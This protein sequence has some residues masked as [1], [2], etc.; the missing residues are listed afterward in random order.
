V[1]AVT[2][3]PILVTQVTDHS[4]EKRNT[5]RAIFGSGGDMKTLFT[6]II[7]LEAWST[8]D[9]DGEVDNCVEALEQRYSASCT[10]TV[11]VPASPNTSS[12]EAVIDKDPTLSRACEVIPE[13]TAK[14]TDIGVFVASHGCPGQ[15]GGV[16]GSQL[17]KLLL[18]L[19][20]STLRKINVLA[21]STA[22]GD[23]GTAFFTDLCTGLASGKLTPMVAA[24]T[25]FVSMAHPKKTK[26]LCSYNGKQFLSVEELEKVFAGGHKVVASREKGLSTQLGQ[27][28]TEQ[29][30]K[31]KKVYQYQGNTMVQVPLDKYHDTEWPVDIWNP[32]TKN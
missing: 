16:T 15:V 11:P 30:A 14:Y 20:F 22:R 5:H 2:S 9:V 21:C 29:R 13:F 18:K 25:G 26:Q 3:S 27:C 19:N 10:L 28:S 1:T 8:I 4:P 23:L 6:F 31:N 32:I 7:K 24:Y 12:W 17:A